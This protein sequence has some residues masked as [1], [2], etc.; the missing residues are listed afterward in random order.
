MDSNDFLS[1]VL[2]TQ[3]NYCVFTQ[4]GEVRK[5]IFVATL[6]NLY[7]TNVQLS[8]QG[9][10]TYYALATF[11]DE[12]S[13]EAVHAQALRSIFIDMDCGVEAKTGKPK[14]FPTKR[15]ANIA[16]NAFMAVTGLDKLGKPWL[17]DSGGGVHAYLPL[18]RDVP[19][20]QWK[21]V[22]EAF[23]RAAS[24]H[25][26]P[27]DVTVTADAARVL[28]MPGTL[29][30]KYTPP[31]PV[32]LKKRGTVF[33]FDALEAVLE[34]YQA[35]LP[36][37]ST[38]LTLPGARPKAAMTPI[39]QAL[40]GSSVT[41]FKNIMVK[42][43]AGTG[44]GQIQHYIDHAAEDGM[45]P[46]WRGAVLSL[47]KHCVDG[48]KAA[49][50]LSALHPY[51]HDRMQRKL[52]EIK[53]PYLCK[54]LD[55]INPGVCPSCPNWGAINSPISLGREIKTNTE[56]ISY[57]EITNGP[58]LN[59]PEPPWLFSYGENGGLFYLKKAEKKNEEDRTI[60]VLPYDFFM[61]DIYY[62]KSER[63][64]E[65]TAVKGSK[66]FTLGIPLAKATNEADCIKALAAGNIVSN[67]KSTDTYLATF[68][69]QCISAKSALG[70]EVAVPPR[71]GWLEGGDFA[72]GDRVISQHG[73]EHDYRYS[74][75]RLQNLIDATQQK[76]T[77][78][79][80]RKPF[81]NM[82][83][84]EQWGYLAFAT[85]SFASVLMHFMPAGAQTVTAHITGEG[86]GNGKSYA[87]AMA[88]SVFGY[89]K[90][91]GVP[92][93]TTHTTMMQRAGLL[94]SLPLSVDE[95]TNKQRESDREFMPKLIFAY[96]AGAHKLKGSNVANAEIRN[97]LFWIGFML[98]SSNTPAL[99]AMMGARGTTSEGEAK[100]LL[101]W[102]VPKTTTLNW[103]AEEEADAQNIN[104]H[105]GV[106]GAKFIAWL[107]TH[108]DVARDVCEKCLVA[109]RQRASAPGT[110]RFW[111][112]GCAA[113]VA[114]NILLGPDYAN[115]LEVPASEIME[116]WYN[117]VI[118]PSRKVIDENQQT[119]MD[120]LN[121]YI[122]DNNHNFIRVA[123][124][125]V[126]GSLGGNGEAVENN[127]RQVKGRVELD[128]ANGVEHTYIETT[129]L[130]QHCAARNIG[131]TSFLQELQASG[132]V[133]QGRKNLTAGTSGAQVRVLCICVT[134][135]VKNPKKLNAG[136]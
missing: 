32:L 6:E 100:R 122:R 108:Q 20:A 38:A 28:R 135:P 34:P 27:I 118:L 120:V 57:D 61:T 106:A 48:D 4:R 125:I 113:S 41:Y 127:R 114:A 103:T 64:A 35:P 123:A 82:I 25:A 37:P 69:R 112:N 47:A 110:E 98:L 45:E 88:N 5:N 9:N 116:F 136:T 79:D 36:K 128:I 23:K 39:G 12:G 93:D 62:D 119:A 131:F 80:W 50:K 117:E 115:I 49:R 71:F 87:I 15:D 133:S 126:V 132:I 59:R 1:A 84:K 40:M 14:A 130:K 8:D 95:I 74:S 73:P 83:R 54:T 94:G 24:Q 31:A 104:N 18:D 17:V 92:P 72:L 26:F 91:F 56:T 70:D 44:C 21:P 78:E 124:N 90:A 68:V 11:D 13:R 67:H 129:L 81:E 107:V 86:S 22:A 76:G 3:G 2:P 77:L 29:N 51:D 99:E 60:C 111:S 30:W 43:A 85:L 63:V 33:A 75:T 19:V 97:D 46:L 89:S 16:L 105:Y 55:T 102:V 52:D 7:N 65:F 121:A 109:W 96:S 42:T 101:E 134:R 58:P 10:Q 53:A 66:I